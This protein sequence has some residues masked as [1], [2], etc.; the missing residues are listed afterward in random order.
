V[1]FFFASAFEIL[2]YPKVTPFDLKVIV[3]SLENVN[4]RT[5]TRIGIEGMPFL[6]RFVIDFKIC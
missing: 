2:R 3:P 4:P 6:L 5:L 1:N